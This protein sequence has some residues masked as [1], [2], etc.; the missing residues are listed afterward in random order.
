[1]NLV[2]RGREWQ[3]FPP[4]Y[5]IIWQAKDRLSYNC[6]HTNPVWMP[7]DLCAKAT[8]KF[9]SAIDCNLP[10]LLDEFYVP[11]LADDMVMVEVSDDNKRAV[12]QRCDLE[13]FAA[14]AWHIVSFRDEYLPYF[15][16]HNDV[17]IK[18]QAEGL[19]I[20]E[21]RNRHAKLVEDLKALKET[22]RG[23]LKQKE[24]A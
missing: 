11:T 13:H 8:V 15:A 3:G 21:V 19:D 6:C 18:P 24:A 7:L 9:V 17:P 10:Y 14:A 1:V 22:V 5:C 12:Q 4:S 2:N 20:I 23:R 16:A